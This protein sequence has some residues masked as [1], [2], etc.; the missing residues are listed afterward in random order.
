MIIRQFPQE[1][2]NL[3]CRYLSRGTPALWTQAMK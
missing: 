3:L 1:Q 2:Y